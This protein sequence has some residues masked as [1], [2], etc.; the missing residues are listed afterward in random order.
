M[1][2]S[3]KVRIEIGFVGGQMMSSLVSTKSANELEVALSKPEAAT[4][5]LESSEGPFTVVLAHVVYVKRFPPEGQ[6]GFLAP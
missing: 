2:E 5:L 4:L 6:I 1:P 3:K